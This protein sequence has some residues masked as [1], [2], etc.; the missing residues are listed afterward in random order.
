MYDVFVSIAYMHAGAYDCVHPL[1]TLCLSC[2]QERF[3]SIAFGAASLL[4][5]SSSDAIRSP[6]SSN[7]LHQQK[8]Q[9]GRHLRQRSRRRHRILQSHLRHRKWVMQVYKLQ[10]CSRSRCPR[11]PPGSIMSLANGKAMCLGEKKR[12]EAH[13]AIIHPY[14]DYKCPHPCMHVYACVPTCMHAHV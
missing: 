4:P 8:L 13:I 7:W 1:N 9:Q 12:L 5:C 6:S 2:A 11:G 14:Y 10:C 3:F